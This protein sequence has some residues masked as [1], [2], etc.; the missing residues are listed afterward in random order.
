MAFPGSARLKGEGNF[1]VSC[2]T[3]SRHVPALIATWS[4]PR[5]GGMRKIFS[6]LPFV[7]GG[8]GGISEIWFQLAHNF[9]SKR[10]KPCSDGKVQFHP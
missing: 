4:R 7:K 10:P 5:Y 6:Q 8:P 2:F 9:I 1:F 3:F